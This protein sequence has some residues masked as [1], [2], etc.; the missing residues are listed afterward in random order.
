MPRL[1]HLAAPALAATL[2]TA[3]GQNITPTDPRNLDRP[4]D[5]SFACVGDLV[6]G[7]NTSDEHVVFTAQPMESCKEW[8]AGTP[9]VGQ[10][11][12][13]T[14]QAATIPDI[15]AFVLQPGKGTMAVIKPSLFTVIDADPLTPG[16]NAIPIGGL[17][18][19]SVA[20]DSG[21]YMVAAN[22]GSCD[23]SALDATTGANTLAVPQI[24]RTTITNASG[25][26]VDAKP[27]VITTGPQR[28]A[29]G[30][31]CP[32]Q[33]TGIA[34]VAYPDCNLVAAVDLSTGEIQGGVK[35]DASGAATLVDGNVQCASQCGGGIEAPPGG[36]A[37]PGMDAGVDGGMAPPPP[38]APDDGAP[39]P[40]ALSF[41]PDGGRLYIGAENSPAVTEVTLGQDRLPESLDSMVLE[42]DVGVTNMEVSPVIPMG[43]VNGQTGTAG[44]FQFLYAISTDRTIRVLDLGDK[45]ECD[46]QADPRYLHDEADIHFLACM[47]VGDSR[48]PPRRPGARSPGIETPRDS[49]PLD[50]SF[51]TVGANKQGGTIS[52]TTMIGTFAFV[53]TSDGFVLVINVD[54][55][56]YPDRESV[57]NPESTYV[58]LA[59]AHQ[60]R[61][62]VNRAPIEPG[63]V[64]EELRDACALPDS[65]PLVLPPRLSQGVGQVL[66]DGELAPEKIHEAPFPRSIRCDI[67]QAGQVIDHAFITEMAFAAP[68]DLRESIFPDLRAIHD[69][70]WFLV[71]EGPVSLD[72][73]TQAIDG[74]SVRNG[75]L[76][77]SGSKLTMRDPAAPFCDMGT[78]PFDILNIVGCDPSLG[79]SQCG[80]GETCFVHPDSAASV[81]SGFCLPADSTDLLSGTCRDFLTSRRRYTIRSTKA[82]TLELG[83][84]RRVLDTTPLD[85]CVSD[86]ECA[87][88]ADLDRLLASGAHPAEADLGPPDKALTYSCEPDPTRAPGPDKCVEVCDTTD[89]CED[90]YSCQS[91]YCV[92]APLPPEQCLS[93]VQRYQV[94]VGE[95]FAVIGDRT[96]FL[97]N[98]ITDP[99]TGECIDDP[100]GN[101][102]NVGRIPLDAPPCT[103]DD[104]LTGAKP[105]PC[106]TTVQQQ[107]SFA[108]LVVRNGQCVARDATEGLI[109]RDRDAPAI[110]FSNPAFTFHLV[111]PWTTGDKDCRDDRLGQF[112]RYS[113]VHEGYQLRLELTGGF[114]PM[115]VGNQINL[116]YPISIAAGPD[117]RLWVLD[118]GDANASVR[119][120]VV[121]FDPGDAAGDFSPLPFL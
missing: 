104:L 9:P 71:W 51:A 117:G 4:T 32:A 86:D 73:A 102:L 84:R 105:D 92:Y 83:V 28:G 13:A 52:P 8:A 94:R 54:D 72:K 80:L 3:C 106:E 65:N 88:M 87:Q 82:G 111:D 89:D 108:D 112:P 115:S 91:G 24:Q 46:T 7:A 103:D 44:D 79:D 27:R 114:V 11:A 25:Q 62:A 41:S 110:R 18:I 66:G 55:D 96:G 76:E 56:N 63:F 23:L 57:S 120:Q 90:G 78:R 81:T 107:E 22:A 38:P 30:V 31:E 119:G 98:R 50:I 37:G 64:P 14:N 85:G 1:K 100:D 67:F 17:P 75:L 53:T 16:R 15:Y 2:A 116:S 34:Y 109:E 47:P 20:D 39:R 48:T 68:V 10:E 61:D 70:Q 69:E 74:P 101:P 45:V 95:A 121:T 19:D 36:D 12:L 60:P 49:V 99:A 35:F 77:R 43:G 29:I 93:T 21:C 26:V 5:V 118:Q 6:V 58:P 113:A 97:H 59:I 40:V 42:G 33:P